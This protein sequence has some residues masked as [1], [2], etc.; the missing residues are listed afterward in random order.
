MKEI[1]T[2]ESFGDVCPRNW[3]Q[4]CDA[5]NEIVER[6]GL[7]PDDPSDND[8]ICRLWEQYCSGDLDNVPE[9]DTR[10]EICSGYTPEGER[11]VLVLDYGGK[12]VFVSEHGDDEP[13]NEEYYEDA[14]DA[15]H[16]IR[17]WLTSEGYRID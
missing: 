11:F 6:R 4:I 17:P 10:E 5:L 14:E 13:F 1:F 7:D 15:L 16:L 8:D 2:S 12:A 9:P 3:K